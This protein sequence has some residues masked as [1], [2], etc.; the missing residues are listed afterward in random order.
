[1]IARASLAVAAAVAALAAPASA[2]EVLHV[3]GNRVVAEND[4]ALPGAAA[5]LPFAPATSCTHPARPPVGR[6]AALAA[7]VPAVLHSDYAKHA[8]T[9]KEYSD[10]K[11]IYDKARSTAARL[12]GTRRRTS[13]A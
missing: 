1:M 6:P 3:H 12:S 10:Y 2:S 8:L 5:E 7:S 9:A 11:G 4:P 13:S